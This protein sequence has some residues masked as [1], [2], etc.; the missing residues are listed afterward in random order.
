MI[1]LE[2]LPS[3]E[4]GKRR[5]REQARMHAEGRAQAHSRTAAAR[6]TQPRS[7]AARAQQQHAAAARPLNATDA[8][9]AHDDDR[10]GIGPSAVAHVP[11]GMHN[12]SAAPAPAGGHV[13]RPGHVEQAP[14]P[15]QPC[16]TRGMIDRR[17]LL[18]TRGEVRF[19]SAAE[20]EQSR[21]E[22]EAQSREAGLLAASGPGRTVTRQSTP[23]A[24]AASAAGAGSGPSGA[25]SAATGDDDDRWGDAPS[26][27]AAGLLDASP[28]QVRP[29][30]D[31]DD[32]TGAL[33]LGAGGKLVMA[34]EAFKHEEMAETA[35]AT[36]AAVCHDGRVAAP[37]HG[38]ISAPDHSQHTAPGGLN[39]AAVVSLLASWLHGRSSTRSGWADMA[40][41]AG[42]DSTAGV[43][44]YAVPCSAVFLRAVATAH[45]QFA[46]DSG[47]NAGADTAGGGLGDA[48]ALAGQT[49]PTAVARL[50]ESFATAGSRGGVSVSTATLAAFALA[51]FAL[52]RR[53]SVTG[54]TVGSRGLHSLHLP[55]A[56]Q[57]AHAA[58]GA[59]GIRSTSLQPR[60]PQAAGTID[61]AARSLALPVSWTRG[62]GPRGADT[63]RST[64][65][66]STGGGGSGNGVALAG[67]GASD[68]PR[69]SVMPSAALSP[70]GP[71]GIGGFPG[72]T[73]SVL[74]TLERGRA[75]VGGGKGLATVAEHAALGADEAV[76]G[77]PSLTLGAAAAAARVPG[78]AAG[79]KSL[80]GAE[81]ARP[82][83]WRPHAGSSAS[84]A[85]VGSSAF[86]HSDM[87]EAGSPLYAPLAADAGAGGAAA[88]AA[89]A[90]PSCG[91]HEL[92]CLCDTDAGSTALL[93]LLSRQ[94][95]GRTVRAAMALQPPAACG[96]AYVRTGGAPD[97]APNVG[98]E[99]LAPALPLAP[100]AVPLSDDVLRIRLSD[101][102]VATHAWRVAEHTT[103][104]Q[105]PL[106]GSGAP[107]LQPPALSACAED[108]GVDA[109][110]ALADDVFSPTAAPPVSPPCAPAPLTAGST[111]AASGNLASGDVARARAR[112]VCNPATVWLRDVPLLLLRSHCSACEAGLVLHALAAT[113]EAHAAAAAGAI[114]LLAESETAKPASAPVRSDAAPAVSSG[115][116]TSLLQHLLPLVRASTPFALG[117]G[118]AAAAGT[119]HSASGAATVPPRATAISLLSQSRVASAGLWG[120]PASGTSAAVAQAAL[121][122]GSRASGLPAGLP[123][124]LSAGAPAVLAAA[125]SAAGGPLDVPSLLARAPA[126][127][128]RTVQPTAVALQPLLSLQHHHD[129][130][131]AAAAQL[132][133]QRAAARPDDTTAAACEWLR[134][135]AWLL[136]LS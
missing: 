96:R 126:A 16:V 32:V 2:L 136:M 4:A 80:A 20:R 131:D 82:R 36:A 118:N 123:A 68:A 31:E 57:A 120:P 61:A 65:A 92:V 81:G 73:G 15:Q 78:T 87:G 47:A 59:G 5:A 25:V 12:S 109:S 91:P 128:R 111:R 127:V 43:T 7:A 60:Q 13:H 71:A 29:L 40:H 58:P 135:Q 33:F 84:A 106:R 98:S 30:S 63:A 110:A 55:P 108:D 79:A 100:P 95:G 39:D 70:R 121:P 37:C 62:G 125:A 122:V 56:S 8:E 114:P 113:A 38:P 130:H 89:R 74:G 3:E 11:A 115:G 22:S 54:S 49:S 102:L 85:S 103:A 77:H 83:E 27:G 69:A 51:P 112:R 18:L 1:P 53:A 66:G 107:R 34:R 119:G 52:G 26:D 21:A 101:V 86:K 42:V 104:P 50:R 28:S 99:P 9:A 17:F 116:A 97:A 134:H 72:I 64:R 14:S 105:G 94:R 35:A 90:L 124:G 88:A 10:W 46:S 44:V 6:D 76:A 24:P 75:A 23:L 93:H 133:P 67:G 41:G 129:H 19:L 48:T 117:A 132:P 45:Q